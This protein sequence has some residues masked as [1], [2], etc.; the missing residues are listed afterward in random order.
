MDVLVVDVLG[1]R[2]PLFALVLPS[3]LIFHF[4]FHEAVPEVEKS[5]G[6]VH[7]STRIHRARGHGW[8]ICISNLLLIDAHLQL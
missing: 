2:L 7:L 3:Y 5:L 1:C 4:P 8:L 6:M